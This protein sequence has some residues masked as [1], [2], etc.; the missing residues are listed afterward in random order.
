MKK[1]SSVSAPTISMTILLVVIGLVF[2]IA[3]AFAQDFDAKVSFFEVTPAEDAAIHVGD[4]ITLRL[5]VRHPADSQVELPSLEGLE[6]WGDFEVISETPVDVSLHGENVAVTRR[7]YVVTVFETGQF[8]TP[9]LDVTHTKANGETETLGSPVVQL[10]VD[11]ILVEGDTELRDIKP[12]AVLPVPPIWPWVLL[13]LLIGLPLIGL[14]TAGGFYFYH[15]WKQR[16]QPMDLP[17]PIPVDTRPA[18]VIAYAELERIE[19]LNLPASDRFKEHYS[20]VTDCLRRYIEGRYTLPALERTTDEMRS[21]FSR[22]PD[23]N[24]EQATRFLTIF[25]DSDLVK[26][27]RF[28][29]QPDEAY[30]LV[31]RARSLVRQTTPEPVPAA[32]LPGQ[33]AEASKR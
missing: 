26:F 33:A 9:R 8:Q 16:L 1:R 22:S 30:Q 13:S 28:K 31:E 11:S 5:E 25:K 21:T 18:E 23:V 7:D 15:R 24:P 4:P 29:P 27:A 6:T 10:D 19:A 17:A 32:P 12:Q 14:V 20:L 3:P 2:S